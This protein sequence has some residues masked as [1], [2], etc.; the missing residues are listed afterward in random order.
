MSVLEVGEAARIL[1]VSPRQV[2]H[3]V[4]AGSITPIARGVVDAQ[5]VDLLVAR[6][7]V[8]HRRPW[9]PETAWAAVSVLSGGD[10]GW[11]GGPQRSRLR[12]RL[13]DFDAERLVERSRARAVVTRYRAH[14]SAKKRLRKRIVT[15]DSADELLGLADSSKVDGY[16]AASELGDVVQEFGL[17]R[18]DSGE[19]TLRATTMPLNVVADLAA[20]S[21]TLAALDLAES[22]D[23]REQTA[24]L[25]RLTRA[26]EEYRAGPSDD[27]RSDTAGRLGNDMAKVAEIA[28]V[29]PHEN[30]ALVGAA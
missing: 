16:V 9:A 22:L 29:F 20:S 18:D 11:L 17:L 26:L 21:T 7:G 13:Y 24:G 15:T 25:A 8:S 1:G 3:L 27:R 4:A 19:V 12:S 10:A 30:G 23:I 28:T 5:S 14:P 2:Q 6:R